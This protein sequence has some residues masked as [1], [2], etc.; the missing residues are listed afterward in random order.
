MQEFLKTK[1]RILISNVKN[2]EDFSR[3][4]MSKSTKT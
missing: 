1:S 4:L 2:V 3:N